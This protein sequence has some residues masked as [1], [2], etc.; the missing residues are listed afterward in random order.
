MVNDIS[1]GTT[2]TSSIT[3][4]PVDER[5][6][7]ACPVCGA[8]EWRCNGIGFYSDDVPHGHPNFGKLLRCPNNPVDAD[9][10]RKDRLREMSNLADF[11]DKQFETFNTAPGGTSLAERNSLDRALKAA[12]EYAYTLDGWLLLDGP[13]GVGK[14]H[15]AA[16]V[17]N[18]RLE[19]GEQVLFITTPDL[20]DHLRS[21]YGPSSEIAYDALFDRVR[22]ADLL[23]LDDFG[24]ENP[25]AW[26]QEKLFQLLNHRYTRRLPTVVT[27]NVRLETL[28]PRLSSRLQ[29]KFVNRATIAAPDF[30]SNARQKRNQ[31]S[32]LD[33]Y[34]YYSLANYDVRGDNAA[35]TTNLQKA[36]AQAQRFVEQMRGWLVY[37]GPSGT[38]KTHL[39]AAIAGAAEAAG[40][41]S[42]FITTPNLLD[43]L[44]KTFD[45]SAG[46]T[47]DDQFQYV[48]HVPLLVLDDLSAVDYNKPWVKEKL[49]QLLNHRYVSNMPT[50]ITTNHT[51]DELDARLRTRIMDRNRCVIFGITV[52]PY[53]E[54][55]GRR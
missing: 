43:H 21:T 18:V 2:P 7:H 44:R 41:E 31:M 13:F 45:P 22:N 34:R 26:A 9:L 50:V 53:V 25:S 46:M 32:E 1:Q 40:H 55:G 11:A 52:R 35:E 17:G 6:D 15:L 10:D 42:V 33:M 28:D 3:N 48:K 5:D 27:T 29:A 24:V 47:F 19:Y 51:M 8:E 36:H 54:R 30:R 38:G 37:M 23:I 14:T 20:L 39:G 12:Q 49:F 16:A 4:G